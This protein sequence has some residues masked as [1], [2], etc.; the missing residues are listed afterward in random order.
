MKK[1]I[2]Q[3]NKQNTYRHRQQ[4]NGTRELKGEGKLNRVKGFIYTDERRLDFGW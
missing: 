3:T 1:K 2:K 4:Y